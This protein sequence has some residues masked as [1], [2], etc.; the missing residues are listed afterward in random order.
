MAFWHH[1]HVSIV[2]K[3]GPFSPLF[4][5]LVMILFLPPNRKIMALRK[6]TKVTKRNLQ[7]HRNII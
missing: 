6:I 3:I 5:A 4:L 1:T 2:E 7:Y